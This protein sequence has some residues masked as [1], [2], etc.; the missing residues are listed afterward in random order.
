MKRDGL[1]VNRR[2]G[3]GSEMI[4]ILELLWQW[5]GGLMAGGLL[6]GDDALDFRSN[7]CNV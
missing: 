1:G 7:S 5:L 4:S 3:H 6:P 2:I